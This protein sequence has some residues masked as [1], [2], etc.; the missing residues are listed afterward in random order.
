[1]LDDILKDFPAAPNV[2]GEGALFAFS[3]MDG[4]TDAASMFVATLGEHPCD[5]LIHTPKQR[6]LELGL[7]GEARP[8]IIAGDVLGLQTDGGDL[9]MTFSCRHTIVADVPAGAEVR[10]KYADGTPAK[11]AA[12]TWVCYDDQ[13]DDAVALSL[14]GNR[15]ALSFARS[16]QQAEQRAAEGLEIEPAAEAAKRLTAYRKLPAMSDPAR[17]R[18]LAKCFSVMRVN[19]LSA[20]GVMQQHWSTPDRVPHKDMWLWDSV[21]H[22]LGMNR[23]DAELSWEFLKSMLDCQLP[24]GR[25]PGQVGVGGNESLS[26]QPPLLAWGVWENYL[27]LGR[28]DTLEYALPR[29]EAYIE[30]DC[31]NRDSTGNGLLE[32]QI[33]SNPLCR[34]GE[35]GLD[36]S[37]RFDEGADLEAVDFSVHAAREMHFMSLIAAELDLEDRA[38]EWQRRG[39]RVS[40]AV[41]DA[42]WCDEDGFY[43]DRKPSGERTRIKAATGFLPLLLEDL[44]A[45][46]A[47]RLVEHL[48]NSDEFATAF[49]VASVAASHPEFSTDMWRGPTWV[50]LNAMIVRG[51]RAHGRHQ[52]AARIASA[53]M[54]HVG[55][56]YQRYGVIFEYFDSVD[57]VPPPRCDRKGPSRGRYDI[58]EKVD[59]IRD[60]HWSAALT[61][62]MLLDSEQAD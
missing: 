13:A 5:L 12:G 22:S 20:E 48:D 53:T 38:T 42:L 47:E 37:P 1:M 17:A 40:A 6:V 21:F 3:G 41:H 49:P 29:L 44:P 34:S 10:L 36:N 59:S 61:A 60:Y 56:Y 33:E 50:N 58:R 8:R 46:R 15:L 52:H 7:G 16:A 18:L 62:E 39:E 57:R 54:E 55:K 4:P 14:K 26:T 23:F 11:Q 27:A 24:D 30:W 19:T 2:W 25:I 51:L 35:S 43:Y 28:A 45:G 9:L 32:W 31:A